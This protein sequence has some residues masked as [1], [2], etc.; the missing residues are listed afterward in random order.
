MRLTDFAV[1]RS[2]AMIGANAEI[3]SVM[4]LASAYGND[5]RGD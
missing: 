5:D 4:L 3:M 1:T 2:L